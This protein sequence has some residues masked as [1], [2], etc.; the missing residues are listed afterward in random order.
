MSKKKNFGN[1]IYLSTPDKKQPFDFETS[2]D[3]LFDLETK[4][5]NLIQLL[6]YHEA[7]DESHLEAAIVLL[8]SATGIITS[9]LEIEFYDE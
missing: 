8:K 7:V 5:I 4:I 2:L 9:D 3:L 1:V 6:D